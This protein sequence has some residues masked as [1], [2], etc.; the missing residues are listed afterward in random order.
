M[1]STKGRVAEEIGINKTSAGRTETISDSFRKTEVEVDDQRI[2]QRQDSFSQ[3]QG[4][5]RR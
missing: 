3:S 4:F 2:E 1:V 5:K